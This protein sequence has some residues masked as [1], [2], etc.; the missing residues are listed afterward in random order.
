MK[1]DL[2]I[3]NMRH[4]LISLL[5]IVITL[6]VYW[7]V[8]NHKFITYDDRDYITENTYV[9]K[10]LSRE[11]IT[12]A[13]TTRYAGNWHPLTWISHMIDCQLYGLN[14]QGHHLTNLLFHAVNTVLLFL[15][16]RRMTGAVWQSAFV[17]VLF[18][19]HP[20]HVESVAWVAERKDVLSSFFWILTMWTYVSYVEQHALYSY[21]LTLLFFVLGLMAK[22]ML[23]T[24]PFILLLLDYWPLGRF[25]FV[26][27]GSTLRSQIHNP[28]NADSEGPFRFLLIWEKIPFFALAAGSS[29]VTFLAQQHEGTIESWEVLPL[30]IRIANALVAYLRYIGKMIWP[31]SLAVIYP[32]LGNTL[33]MWQ[34]A[35]AGLMLVIVS[36]LVIWAARWRPYLAVGW[37]W[38]IGTLVPV[39]GILQVGSQSIADR[40]MYMPLIGLSII[41][42]WGIPELVVRWCHQKIGLVIITGVLLLALI[43]RT[44]QQLRY[45]H[46]SITLFE[47]AV[48]VTTN[49]WV[50]QGT[51]GFSLAAEGKI[52][53]AIIHY[54]E[55]VRINPNNEKLHY[56]LGF[57]LATEGKIA[58]AIVHF[59]E[60]V[61]INPDYE[62]AHNNLGSLLATEGKIAEAI[63]HFSE[64]LRINP[65]DADVHYNLGIALEREKKLEGAIAHYSE[66]LRIKP[67]YREARIALER[68]LQLKKKSDSGSLSQRP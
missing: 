4:H 49:N 60:A 29:V 11:G 35:G 31:S 68:A 10:G 30:N 39:I 41:I 22:P 44:W 43:V 18:A 45:W 7:Q 27:S 6:A 36:G 59:S 52:V 46:D 51:L 5:L 24:L 8:R 34:V 21:L 15:V 56:D 53:E 66:V 50:A 61:R 57:Y 9:Q 58:E 23:V 38:Y 64:A 32:H 63:V 26:Q 13:F 67:D 2:K 62:E 65:V 40:Y 17:A 14:A 16:F 1:H 54:S 42:A 47:H 20:L 55:A 12:W 3:E 33:P 48:N 28:S 37:L 25:Q 19:V